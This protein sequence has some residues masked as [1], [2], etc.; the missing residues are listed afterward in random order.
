MNSDMYRPKCM[1]AVQLPLYKS[2]TESKQRYQ[3]RQNIANHFLFHRNMES[4]HHQS[5]P[6]APSPRPRVSTDMVSF[7]IC[8]IVIEKNTEPAMA[9][10]RSIKVNKID[11]NVLLSLCVLQSY[12]KM[13]EL[14]L[15]S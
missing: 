10:H 3:R 8:G 2:H 1:S 14:K 4:M 15:T 9:H 6:F 7:R 12:F 5:Q 13:C 11:V